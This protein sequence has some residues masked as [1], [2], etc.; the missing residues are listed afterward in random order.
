MNEA[1]GMRFV[2]T[3]LTKQR[4]VSVTVSRQ[5]VSSRM[6]R[7]KGGAQ[8]CDQ[9]DGGRENVTCITLLVRRSQ[10]RVNLHSRER[11]RERKEERI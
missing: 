8:T 1:Q 9:L 7:K 2:S 6:Q 4:R 10:V 3:Q 11:E 5:R